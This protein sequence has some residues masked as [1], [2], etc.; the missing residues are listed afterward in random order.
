MPMPAADSA[1]VRA[2]LVTAL[3]LDLI[4]P[5]QR[6]LKALDRLPSSWY[7]TGFLVPTNTDL[8]LRRDD[9]ADD[10]FAGVDGLPIPLDPAAAA[11]RS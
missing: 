7:I 1:Q 2:Q 3:E 9:T 10:D 11:E 8:S 5:T 6:V 4:G